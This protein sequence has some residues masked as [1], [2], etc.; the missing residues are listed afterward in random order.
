MNVRINQII[1]GIIAREGLYVN[2]PNDRGGPTKYGITEMVARA[3]GYTGDMQD[4]PV[5]VAWDIYYGRYVAVPWFDRIVAMS[6]MVGEELI[7]TGVNMGPAVASTMFQ[8]W[9]NGLNGQERWYPDLFA[10][11][12]IGKLTIAAFEK[13]LVKRGKEGER[14]MLAALNGTQAARYLDIAENNQTQED[15]LYGWIRA[16][17]VLPE[18]TDL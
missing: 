11:G 2:H 8:R 16:R 15:F 12:R 18:D 17:V 13:Y 5:G 3:N 1:N 4:L 6:E 9:L 10:D 14:V 7:D